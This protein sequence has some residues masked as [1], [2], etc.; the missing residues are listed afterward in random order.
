MLW[1]PW[2]YGST[3]PWAREQLAWL[4]LV[5]GGLLVAGF[6]ARPRWPHGS[7]WSFGLL[8]GLLGFGWL[9]ALN[10]PSEFLPGLEAF[11]PIKQSV[12]WLPG[13]VDRATSAETM[14]LVTGLAAAFVVAADC[15]NERNWRNRLWMAMA[16]T[17]I[18]I[19][20]LG[21]AQRASGTRVIFGLPDGHQG[22]IF[23]T[24]FNRNNGAAF[25]N[26]VLPLL[27]GLCA[28]ALR[29]N[30]R[31]SSRVLWTLGTLAVAATILVSGSRGGAAV[32]TFVFVVSAGWLIWSWK[33]EKL[34]P[35][36]AGRSLA[37]GAI[38]V[39]AF[40][41][42]SWAAG[43]TELWKRLNEADVG[44]SP[45][46]RWQVYSLCKRV[47]A[48]AGW[49]GFG[50]GAF[51]LIFPS[52]TSEIPE[53]DAGFWRYAH[54][55]Y[56]QTAIEWGWAG[57]GAWAVL[58]FGG[59]LTG[60]RRLFERGTKLFA[61]STVFLACNLT[62]LVGVSI[63]ATVDFPLQIA[64]IQLYSVIM[65]GV[66]WSLRP[67]TRRRHTGAK[68]A[69]PAQSIKLLEPEPISSRVEN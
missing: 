5:L 29:P 60:V 59:L 64:S 21:L 24:Y 41:V 4:L 40:F 23:A 47:A 65:L 28:L 18:G 53:L 69:K 54:N 2:V 27:T 30:G 14:R 25:C 57:A 39:G 12:K 10:A 35:A 32:G 11:I 17:A 46:A 3:P 61:G 45:D 38:L 62:G 52:Y 31:Q 67:S 68:S 33:Q 26:L 44:I 36:G 48:D 55:D 43:W 16:V 37:V 8:G 13:S 34:R 56:W 9:M 42:L 22:A 58:L 15:C 66:V 19:A 50:P 20:C 7:K 6:C 63:H 1:G 49:W 51:S